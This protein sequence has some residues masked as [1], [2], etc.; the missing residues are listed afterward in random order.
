ML[1]SGLR[2]QD[3]KSFEDILSN[4]SFSDFSDLT[5]QKKKSVPDMPISF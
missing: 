5:F 1:C 4:E 3:I 2:H